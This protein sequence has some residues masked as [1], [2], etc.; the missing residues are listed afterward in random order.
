MLKQHCFITTCLV[1][2]MVYAQLVVAAT[3]L[4]DGELANVSGGGSSPPLNT[5]NLFQEQQ[6]PNQN[7]TISSVGNQ[8][9]SFDGLD[10]SPV[11]FAIL[12]SQ[13]VLDR[14]RILT[15]T[16]SAQHGLYALNL[17]NQLSSDVIA[18]TNVM[19]G[20]FLFPKDVTPVLLLSQTSQMSQLYRYQ[21]RLD[22]ALAG[23]HH[24]TES[25]TV[26]STADFRQNVH[27]MVDQ[28]DISETHRYSASTWDVEVGKVPRQEIQL[29]DINGLPRVN[30]TSTNIVPGFDLGGTVTIK[31]TQYGAKAK[32]NG[33]TLYGPQAS[34]DAVLLQQQ[35]LLIEATLKLP[36]LDF[37]EI[38]G[39]LGRCEPED[40]RTLWDAGSIG[41]TN[42]FSVLKAVDDQFAPSDPIA[43]SDDGIILKGM[44]SLLEDELNLNAGFVLTGEGRLAL[45]EPASVSIGGEISFK[46]TL[47]T[48]FWIDP[49]I[50]NKTVEVLTWGLAKDVF[51]KWEQDTEY[52]LIDVSIPFTLV[53]VEIPPFELEYKGTV[54]AQLGPGEVSA[55]ELETV[56]VDTH[57]EDNTRIE[58]SSTEAF[59]QRSSSETCEHSSFTGGRMTGAEAELLAMS[60]GTL[61]VNNG[62]YISFS[63]Q[64][65]QG[66]RV[67]H[68]VNAV[69]SIAANSLN[70]G[71]TP[72]LVRGT[73]GRPQMSLQQHNQFTQQR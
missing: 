14:P 56:S 1:L 41:G 62:N 33:T 54:I 16:G 43:F 44:G 18:A 58:R 71:Q 38:T 50:I 13:I 40:Y 66:M 46:S 37:G 64:A 39:C 47:D 31:G 26:I 72:A 12:Q 63:S 11:V 55:D 22:S 73:S 25:H 59:T 8:S 61:L 57:F 27:S 34:I 49:T 20:G 6:Q 23:N 3:Q 15:L 21:G 17:E 36:E 48:H 4:S 32:Y 28:H 60:E 9:Q 65:Q 29:P 70:L 30:R 69:S 68:G 10:T 53:D 67:M 51:D 35:D 2:S 19:G 7:G 45:S 52:A 5:A 24:E 42:I